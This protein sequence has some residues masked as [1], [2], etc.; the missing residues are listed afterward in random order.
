MAKKHS[1]THLAYA[2]AVMTLIMIII[3]INE[4]AVASIFTQDE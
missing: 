3:K 2:V 1:V 4:D